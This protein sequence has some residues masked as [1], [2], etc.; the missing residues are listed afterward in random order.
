MLHSTVKYLIALFVL[1][2]GFAHSATLPDPEN[3]RIE[4]DLIVWDEVPNAIGYNIYRNYNYYDTV[5]GATSFTPGQYGFYAIVAFDAQGNFG[6]PDWR[7][8]PGVAGAFEPASND[9]A[10]SVS[11]HSVIV[12]NTCRDVGP[13]ES[14]IASCNTGLLGTL[15][16][17]T[18]PGTK[19]LSGGACSTSDI[20]E[21]D[22][23]V[24]E[25]T[26]K[27]TVPTFSGEVVTQA[28][29]VR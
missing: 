8:P 1:L 14:C 4:G 5:K 7:D 11:A 20:I 16:G 12:A 21:A 6:A 28:I 27:C 2:S 3:I 25:M 29:C 26:Y 24:T 23:S 10:Y 9:I 15:S 17:Q 13:G 19:Y 22:A 18:I